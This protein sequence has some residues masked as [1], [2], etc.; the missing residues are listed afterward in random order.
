MTT[1]A[2]GADT[3]APATADTVTDRARRA[4]RG[5]GHAQRRVAER[6][7]IDE[8]KLSKSLSGSRQFGPQELTELATVTGVTTH[9]LL[10][11]SDAEAGATSPIAMSPP[12]QAM[13]GPRPESDEQAMRR[14]IIV[15]QAWWLFAT[16]GFEAVRI[17]DIA[18]QSGVS[19]ATVHYYF[20][21]KRDLFTEALQYSVNLAFNRQIAELHSIVDPAAKLKRLAQIQLPS[22]DTGRA[23]W[24]IWL[25]TWTHVTV[26]NALTSI[27][28]ESYRRWQQTVRG[29]I[30]EGQQAGV[31]RYGSTDGL[32]ENMTAVIDG[33]G[34]KVLTG[35]LTVDQMEA[36]INA[37]IDQLIR[38][39]RADQNSRSQL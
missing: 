3:D 29:I 38:T 17:S 26:D 27:H 33:L 22:G 24:S 12:S 4:I 36:H 1:E 8:T 6:M 35:I 19:S 37:H 9:W 14:R 39:Q 5:S 25:Q 21:G 10:T 34:I 18:A 16:H 11:G 28:L 31:F 13:T 20:S 30:H 23:E 7:A 32:A 15:E 2:H